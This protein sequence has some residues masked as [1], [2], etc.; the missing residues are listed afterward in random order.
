VIVTAS[1]MKFGMFYEMK[2]GTAQSGR[3][4]KIITE[5]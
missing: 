1:V 5:M 4:E 3:S 2:S